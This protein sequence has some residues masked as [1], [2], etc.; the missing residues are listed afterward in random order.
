MPVSNTI[1]KVVGEEETIYVM[2]KK[3]D[4]I[5][6]FELQK[7]LNS[8]PPPLEESLE[9]VVVRC[10]KNKGQWVVLDKEGVPISHHDCMVLINA[11]FVSEL[12]DTERVNLGCGFYED[13]K[14]HIGMAV[15]KRLPQDKPISVPN[16]MVNRLKFNPENGNFY[17]NG[18]C[19]KAADYLIL[20]EGCHSEII[21]PRNTLKKKS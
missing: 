15:G 14:T 11:A 10:D 9:T 12:S 4:P 19:F 13:R 5:G 21:A 8:S 6:R 16:E 17:C 18:R 7:L 2:E 3:S 20:K 1:T